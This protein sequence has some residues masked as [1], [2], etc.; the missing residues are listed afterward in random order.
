[1]NIRSPKLYIAKSR[2]PKADRGVFAQESF[3]SGDIIEVCPILD[4]PD[5]DYEN[6]KK[7]ILRNYYFMWNDENTKAVLALG[8]GMLYNHSYHP[9]ATYQKDH[10]NSTVTFRA[11]TDIQKNEEITVN[12]NFGNPDNKGKLWINEVP[13][14]E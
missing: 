7:T 8:Y 13:E 6:M 5:R 9:N 12:Y 1:M 3:R 10:V 14:Y 4:V 2:I 11:I